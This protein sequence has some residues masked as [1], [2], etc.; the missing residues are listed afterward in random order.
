LERSNLRRDG[1]LAQEGR[2]AFDKNVG[3]L[4]D[5]FILSTAYVIECALP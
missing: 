4:L 5:F 2:S 3:Q 1:S